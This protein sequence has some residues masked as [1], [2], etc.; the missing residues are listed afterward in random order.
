M[1]DG[2]TTSRGAPSAKPHPLVVE[3]EKPIRERSF[4]QNPKLYS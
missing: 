1:A 2:Y 3:Q 4:Y